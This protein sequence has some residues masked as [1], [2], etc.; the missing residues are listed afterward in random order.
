[1]EKIKGSCGSEN[2]ERF[3]NLF[4]TPVKYKLGKKKSK[5]TN[6]S[7]GYIPSEKNC[8]DQAKINLGDAL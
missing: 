8:K 4:N 5:Q 2:L 7:F 6:S 1:M 3:V